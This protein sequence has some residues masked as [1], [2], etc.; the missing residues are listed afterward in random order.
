[1]VNKVGDNLDEMD[2]VLLRI[3]LISLFRY[4]VLDK[5]DE[6]SCSFIFG[7]NTIPVTRE[8]VHKVLGI[9]MG[10]IHVDALKGTSCSNKLMKSWRLFGGNIGE[11]DII[12]LDWCTYMIEC[13]VN[14]KRLWNRSTHYN[15]PLVM[16]LIL[17][18]NSTKSI[19]QNVK[20]ITPAIAF[21]T[22][23]L[24]N[25]REMEEISSGG[26]GYMN[27][28]EDVHL[29]DACKVTTFAHIVPL[30]SRK[31]AGSPTKEIYFDFQKHCFI[32]SHEKGTFYKL[33]YPTKETFG[34]YLSST[35]YNTDTQTQNAA[36]K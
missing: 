9:P 32:Y 13:L 24:L 12:H 29:A 33:P 34:N 31:L 21:W 36:E 5:F 6:D 25:K 15:G 1:M 10:I 23:S 22:S 18:A 17:Y 4:W 2:R 28:V 30:R 35:G 27:K 8:A 20:R 16:L 14:T 26:F 11:E 3:P 7:G 19:T